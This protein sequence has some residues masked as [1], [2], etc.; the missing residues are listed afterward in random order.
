MK[1]LSLL[2][3]VGVSRFQVNHKNQNYQT[4]ITSNREWFAHLLKLVNVLPESC[5]EAERL[6]VGPDQEVV[7]TVDELELPAHAVGAEALLVG[8]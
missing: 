6:V 2:R 4:I 1:L 7:Q 5:H 3:I 8:G